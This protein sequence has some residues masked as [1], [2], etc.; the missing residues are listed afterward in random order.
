MREKGEKMRFEVEIS[1]HVEHQF[2]FTETFVF[3]TLKE[4]KERTKN[5]RKHESVISV[6][7]YHLVHQHGA[8]LPMCDGVHLFTKKEFYKENIKTP[9]ENM[10]TVKRKE[11]EHLLK[12]EVAYDNYCF[13]YYLLEFD[14]DFEYY[15]RIRVQYDLKKHDRKKTLQQFYEHSKSRIIFDL[16]LYQYRVLEKWEWS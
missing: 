8:T 6:K 2:H 12:D 16:T 13:S 1:S 5:L 14:P 11:Y 3:R 15:K 4:A 7:E 9:K 10:K